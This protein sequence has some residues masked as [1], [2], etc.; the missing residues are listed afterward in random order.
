[1]VQNDERLVQ[2]RFLSVESLAAA[3]NQSLTDRQEN[4]KEVPIL[5][6]A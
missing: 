4:P 2:R 6:A 1:V 3:R 5:G